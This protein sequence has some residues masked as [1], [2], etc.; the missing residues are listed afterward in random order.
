MEGA[1]YSVPSN[2][3]LHQ[4]FQHNVHRNNV[5][6]RIAVIFEGFYFYLFLFT[7]FVFNF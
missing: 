2:M 7:Y 6:D 1:L 3:K 4:L 5:H